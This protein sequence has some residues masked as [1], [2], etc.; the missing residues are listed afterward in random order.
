MS[1]FQDYRNQSKKKLDKGIMKILNNL[2]DLD[3][4]LEEAKVPTKFA[5]INA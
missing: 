5:V 1:N 3:N 4:L 2:V